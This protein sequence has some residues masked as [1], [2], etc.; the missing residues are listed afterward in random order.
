[1]INRVAADKQHANKISQLLPDL[2]QS[3]RVVHRTHF[4]QGQ[5]H[6]LQAVCQQILH[7]LPGFARGT[8]NDDPYTQVLSWASTAA[9]NDPPCASTPAR[10]SAATLAPSAAALAASVTSALIRTRTSASTPCGSPQA[11]SRVSVSA[12]NVANAAKGMEQ[13]PPMARLTAR[14]AATASQVL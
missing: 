3:C 7:P 4:N 5:C 12:F 6:C 13:L 10:K 11:A 1:M 14:S 8:G 9:S 2:H